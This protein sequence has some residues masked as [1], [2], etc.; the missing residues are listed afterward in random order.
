[1]PKRATSTSYGATRGNTGGNPA[2]AGAVG[3]EVALIRRRARVK[4]AKLID[5][6][7][8]I[9]SGEATTTVVVGKGEG[10]R[11]IEIAPN[12][13]TRLHAME[14]LG[15]YGVGPQQSVDV[16][17]QGNAVQGVVFLPVKTT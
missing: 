11:T 2:K 8:R 12:F 6:A 7:Y 15:R 13:D 1:M 3:T 16:T 9:G 14:V 4:F 17:T 5:E 10:R